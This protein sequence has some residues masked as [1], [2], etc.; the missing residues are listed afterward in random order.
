MISGVF[1]TQIL[2]FAVCFSTFLRVGAVQANTFCAN[3]WNSHEKT[4]NLK[5]KKSWIFCEITTISS[6]F[7][8]KS[9]NLGRK[10]PICSPGQ[11]KS[12]KILENRRKSKKIEENLRK[13]KKTKENQRKPKKIKE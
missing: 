11:A 13:S 5:S 3:V 6:F 8:D 1:A 9:P 10:P 2:A 7:H 4:N 12:K